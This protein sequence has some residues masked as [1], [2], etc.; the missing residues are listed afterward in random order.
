MKNKTNKSEVNP[1][2][3][4]I[5]EKKKSHRSWHAPDL[6]SVPK[7]S[8]RCPQ[9]VPKSPDQRDKRREK[10]GERGRERERGGG[11]NSGAKVPISQRKSTNSAKPAQA[12]RAD[13]TD[14]P[15]E[16][17]RQT[18]RRGPKAPTSNDP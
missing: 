11:R 8:P 4:S 7:M 16:Q 18:P 12:I 17:Y 13:K 15:A 1:N 9:D 6:Y 3:N 10:E 5:G 2:G 14:S